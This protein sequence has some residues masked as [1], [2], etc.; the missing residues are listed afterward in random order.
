MSRDAV[1]Q[2]E[3]LQALQEDRLVT[4]LHDLAIFVHLADL[5]L[6]YLTAFMVRLQWL[7]QPA[8]APWFPKRNLHRGAL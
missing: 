6:L 7:P 5:M 4:L 2:Q 1:L 8:S 3:I